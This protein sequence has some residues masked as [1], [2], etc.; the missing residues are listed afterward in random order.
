MSTVE[1]C[2]SDCDNDRREQIRMT[3]Q[4]AWD[5]ER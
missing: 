2:G 5:A 4:I 1:I 3:E